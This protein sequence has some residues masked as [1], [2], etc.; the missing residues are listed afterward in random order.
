MNCRHYCLLLLIKLPQTILHAWLNQVV[1]EFSKQ[2]KVCMPLYFNTSP[3]VSKM[4][5]FYIKPLQLLLIK[6]ETT[7]LISTPERIWTIQL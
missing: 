4:A 3:T 2:K 5:L 1:T 6:L 7:V